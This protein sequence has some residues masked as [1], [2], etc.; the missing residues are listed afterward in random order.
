[1]QYNK[2]NIM[3]KSTTLFGKLSR[4]T[5][6]AVMVAGTMASLPAS[7]DDSPL[8]GL[9]REDSLKLSR[10]ITNQGDP[11]IRNMPVLAGHSYRG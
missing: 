1:M 6:A 4:L 7:G 11:E 9:S 3:T 5:L 8:A 2:E 10:P